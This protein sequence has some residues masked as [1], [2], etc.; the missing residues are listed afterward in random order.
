MVTRRHAVSLLLATP[1]GARQALAQ[2]ATPLPVT[3][4]FSILADMVRQVG[5]DHVAVTALVGPDGDA[6]SYAPTPADARALAAAKVVVVNGL[7]FEGWMTRLVR[8]SG[9]RA[10]VVTAST[11][12]TP[13]KAEEAHGHGHSHD[14]AHG[15]NDPHAWQSVANAR[16]YV[17][18]I[19]SGLAEA[20]PTQGEAFARNAAAYDA[21]LAALDAEIRAAIGAIPRAQRRLLTTHD[22]FR[23]FA[24]AYEVDVLAV[25]G[26]SADSEPS[27]R[28]IAALIRQIRQGKVKALFME[29]ISDPRAIQR[30]SAE[31]GARI[32]GKLYS[33]AL[34]DAGGPAA[35]YVDMMRHNARQIAGA[36]AHG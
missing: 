7:G 27:A 20:A 34:S 25:R 31:T 12:V 24:K 16:L 35:T 15:A 29:N 28:Q 30:I 3:A 18:A 11:G 8:S 19:A 22:A 14:N 32:G 10:K 17:K 2:V 6:H 33:D 21:T 1:F 4:S 23:Y 36:M 26:V 5:G 13:L 9:T